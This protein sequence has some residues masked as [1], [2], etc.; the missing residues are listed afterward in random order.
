MT[1]DTPYVHVISAFNAGFV[2]CTIT[3]PIWFIKTRMQL[4]ESM[5]G[6]STIKCIRDIYQTSGILAFYKGLSASYFGISETI[7]HFV[8]YEFLKTKM[9]DFVSPPEKAGNSTEPPESKL[10]LGHFMAAAATSKFCASVMTYPHG[11]FL[12][13][14][15][16]LLILFNFDFLFLLYRGCSYKI[17]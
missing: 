2:S 17:T 11:L 8:I 1:P 7:I 15:F 10:N 14:L 12:L 6:L 3:N 13:P 9:R 4:D 16:S 5:K